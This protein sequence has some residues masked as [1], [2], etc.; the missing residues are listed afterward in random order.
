M[1]VS[2]SAHS[3]LDTWLT[4]IIP[5]TDD[6]IAINAAI[7]DGGRCGGKTCA[8]STTTPAIIYFPPGTYIVSNPIVGYYYTQ[9]IGDPTDMPVIK[10]SSSFPTGL[11]AMIETNP[12]QS[13][14]SKWRFI[15]VQ[16]P[17]SY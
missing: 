3:C 9:M 15:T 16:S 8:G 5:V 13:N 1:E 17:L 2:L 14:G 11:L 12:Y 4:T 10:A 7:S 6:T